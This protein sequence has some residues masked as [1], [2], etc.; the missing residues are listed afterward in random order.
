M[1]IIKDINYGEN[2]SLDLY[3]P[4]TKSFPVFIYFHGGGLEAGDK[5]D[6]AAFAEYLN[7]RNIAVVSANYRMYPA[8][9]YPQFVEDAAAAV[10]WTCKNINNYGSC[11]K[12]FVGGSSAGG[13]LSMLLCFDKKYLAAYNIDSGKISGYIHD[14]GQPTAHFN[15]LRER[16]ID[17]RRVIIDET[18]PLYHVGVDPDCAPMLIIVSDN[19]IAGRYEQTM[20]LVSALKQFGQVEPKVKLKVMN[21]Q[22]CEYDFTCDKDGNNILGKMIDEYIESLMK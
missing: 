13:Y 7:D 19:D 6:A 10:A 17:P 9:V 18:A 1:K 8:A 12:Y 16:G 22:H 15:V 3:L 4:E 20:L 21:G 5:S 2:Q 11:D 14:A